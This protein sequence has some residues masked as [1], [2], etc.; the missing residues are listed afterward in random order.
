MRLPLTYQGQVERYMEVVHAYVSAAAPPRAVAPLMLASALTDLGRIQEA[1]VAAG[2][3][4]VGNTGDGTIL[5]LALRL[6]LAIAWNDAHDAEGLAGQLAP[7]A[8]LAMVVG[9]PNAARLIG[10]AALLRGDVSAARAHFELAVERTSQIRYR[11]E[12]ALSRLELAELLLD[13]FRTDASL[14]LEHLRAAKAE[15]EALDMRRFSCTC[16]GWG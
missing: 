8:H 2:S 7:V 6:E 3:L 12:L 11:P 13:H 4:G 15:F 16:V 5:D 14:A 1:H 10:N 9:M